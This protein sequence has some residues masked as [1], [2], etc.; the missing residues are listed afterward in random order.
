MNSRALEQVG[1]AVGLEDHGDDVG[2]V[3][4]VELDEPRR[5]ARA[6]DSASRARSRVEPARS[7]AQLVLELLRAR[8]AWRRG[9]SAS[10]AWRRRQ[11]VDVALQRV[12]ALRV[13]RDVGRQDPLAA[14]S[15][16][17][18]LATACARSSAGAAERLARPT[19]RRAATE[20][21]GRAAGRERRREQRRAQAGHRGA[22]MLG[23]PRTRSRARS[24]AA[25]ELQGTAAR[26]GLG[27][28]PRSSDSRSAARMVRTCAQTHLIRQGHRAPGPDGLH[29]VPARRASTSC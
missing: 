27:Y 21:A 23:R 29:A 28:E 22:S 2:L 17:A 3:G 12:D 1:E 8:R 24:P 15:A 7:R 9:R 20:P 11:R 13:A 4:L 26:Q 19:S 6:R 14:P 25:P 18:D 16:P 10:R 5:R